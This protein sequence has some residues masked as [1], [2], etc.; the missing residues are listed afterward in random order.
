MSGQVNEG[1]ERSPKSIVLCKLFGE[2]GDTSPFG[3]RSSIGKNGG[4]RLR[5]LGVQIT[6]G[7]CEFC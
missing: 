5:R 3:A 1:D 2:K 4:L 6:S 7:A